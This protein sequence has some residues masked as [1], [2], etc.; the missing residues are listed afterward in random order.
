M[1]STAERSR[2]RGQ[3]LLTAIVLCA[4]A[5]RL[6][7]LPLLIDSYDEG[8]YVA[9]L[10]LMAHGAPLYGAIAFGQTPLFLASLLPWYVVLGGTIQAARV[11][12]IALSL[13]GL[14]AAWVIGRELG[15]PRTALIALALLA[16]DPLYLAQSVA[17]QAEVPTLAW[18]LVALAAAARAFRRPAPWLVA[19]AGVASAAAILSKLAGILVLVPVLMLLAWPVLMP[20]RVEAH[21]TQAGLPP[22]RWQAHVALLWPTLGWFVAGFLGLVL[23]VLWPLAPDLG[24]M[25]HQVF[26]IRVAAEAIPGFSRA[27]N[28]A[29]IASAWWEAPLLLVAICGCIGLGRQGRWHLAALGVWAAL[30]L[31][32]LLAQSPL[33]THH[34]A[35]AVP[36]LVLL[37]AFWL[38]D[39]SGLSTLPTWGRTHQ[40]YYVTLAALLLLSVATDA[41]QWQDHARQSPVALRQVAHDL[42]TMTGPGDLVITDDPLIAVLADR[43]LPANLADTSLVRIAAGQLSTKEVEAAAADPHVTA[44]LWYSGRFDHLPGLLAWVQA[45]FSERRDYGN[46]RALWLR[47][48]VGYRQMSVSGV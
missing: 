31:G 19:L 38:G 17:V 28:L 13:L 21:G 16:V 46:G 45:H 41:I 39:P 48:P 40:L 2:G 14:G 30:S 3:Q 8:S 44:I 7:N 24:A 5:I 20:L 23:L 11:G 10:H 26:A 47:Q 32:A 25:W 9:S 1:N 29:T 22:F 42:R 43:T 12:V 37:A 27:S 6:V 34:L 18:Q 4:L 15:G 33:F 35:L 36:P